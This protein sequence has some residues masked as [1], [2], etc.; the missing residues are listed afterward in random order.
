MRK[1]TAERRIPFLGMVLLIPVAFLTSRRSFFWCTVALWGVMIVCS[2]IS[3]LSKREIPAIRYVVLSLS[4]MLLL[5]GIVGGYGYTFLSGS[6]FPF[7]LPAL[8]IAVCV[9]GYKL[10][11]WI[12][13]DK[14]RW[15]LVV[16]AVIMGACVFFYA[17][18]CINFANY[19]LDRSE[20]VRQESMIYGKRADRSRKTLGSY[21]FEIRVDGKT[22]SID[23]S[24]EDYNYYQVGDT[25][26]FAEYQGAFG[27]PFYLAE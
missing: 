17:S 13:F 15:N 20:P 19:A 5:A 18:S 22:F 11:G 4:G 3:R 26:S 1:R 21:K 12:R 6:I 27:E 25:F 16:V 9:S 23:V 2:L 7:W 10:W 24:R 14:K 8:P